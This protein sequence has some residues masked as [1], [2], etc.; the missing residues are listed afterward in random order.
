MVEELVKSTRVLVCAG[1]GGVGKTTVSASLG[2]FAAKLGLRVLV[3]TIDPAK[4]LAT[5]LGIQADFVGDVEVPGQSYAG[6]LSAA[7]IHPEI[8]F[9]QFIRN[10]L[11]DPLKE[12]RLLKNSLYRQLATTLS[13]SQEFTSLEKLLRSV[14][15]NEYDLIILDTPPAQHAADFL[16]A[17]DKIY[18]L[19][20][21]S[22][23]K[24]FV[25]S[26]EFR[27][28]GILSRVLKRGTRTVMGAL[29]KITGSD[30]V[31]ELGL[32]F[33]CVWGLQG[34]IRK[35]SL[36]V[37]NLLS[38]DQTKFVLVSGFDESKLLEGLEFKKDLQ[39]DGYRLGA[40]VIN[41][42]FPIWKTAGKNR[43]PG[44]K[45][46]ELVHCLHAL[47]SQFSQYHQSRT[48][49]YKRFEEKIETGTKILRIPDMNIDIYGID[50]LEK[51]SEQFENRPQ[52]ESV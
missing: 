19:F 50:G 26:P 41:R 6:K 17:P 23:M 40:V 48:D 2:V 30:F 21:D 36:E 33:E 49:A 22:I 18:S 37:K 32:F 31:E 52:Q 3:L 38:S 16:S 20:Q 24:W 7:L 12:E 10:T 47:H 29:E 42:A 8:I 9:E 27:H 13:G 14:E 5:S 28:S 45:E 35:R 51:L 25:K 4:R 43:W 44:G 1:S 34:Q 15:S 46:T 39:T 11:K